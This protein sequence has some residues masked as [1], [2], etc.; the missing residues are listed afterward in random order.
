MRIS[1]KE[2]TD[3]QSYARQIKGLEAYAKE[4]GIIYHSIFKDDT[5]G[6]TFNRKEWKRLKAILRPGDTVIMKEISRFT[7]EAEQGYKTYM[8]LMQEGINLIFL[9]NPTVCTDYIK[10]LME[11]AKAQSLVTKTVMESTIKLLLI[12]ELDRVE[13]ERE[14]MIKRIKQGMKASTKTAGRKEGQILYLSDELKED[15]KN[16]LSDRDITRA[17][18]AKKHSITR[19]T[20]NKYIDIVKAETI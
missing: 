19:V 5:T 3:K 15:I 20:L 11:T 7:R 13:Q 10:T 1:T 16:L 9:D 8:E 2:E 18:V 12:V 6:S 17:S 14:I 4:K